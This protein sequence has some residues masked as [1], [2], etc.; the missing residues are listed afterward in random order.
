MVSSK[1]TP[2][3][4]KQDLLTAQPNYTAPKR[5]TR[6]TRPYPRSRQKQVL[7]FLYHHRIPKTISYSERRSTPARINPTRVLSGLEED[8]VEDGFRRPTAAEA[9]AY[10]QIASTESVYRWWKNRDSIWKG[11]M[12]KFMPPKW[13]H[14][15][16]ELLKRFKIARESNKIVTIHWFRRTA[17]QLWLQLYPHLPDLFVFSNGWFWRFL[18]RHDIVRRRITKVATKPP[19]ELVKVTNAFIQ[20]IRKRSRRE[21]VYQTIVLRSSPPY[22]P[23]LSDTWGKPA[24]NWK[25]D[26]LRRFPL[27][28]IVNLDETPLP[29]EF[30]SGYSYDFKGV[31]TVAGKSERSGWDKRQATIILY[32]MADGSTP[33]KPVII[34]HGKG[35]VASKENYD[36]RVDVHFNDTAYNNEELFHTW[37]SD[38]YQPYVAQ[39]AQGNE[40]SL[41]VMDAAS[42]HKTETILD[43]IRQAEPPMTT[44]L[45]PPG[46]TSLVQPLDTAV[47]GP[48]KK[49]LQEEA[50]VYMEELENEDRMPDSWAIKDRREMATVIVA[51]AWERLRSDYKL[52]KQS[53]IQC[54]ISIHPD[55]H[56]DHLINIKGV[57]NSSIDPNGWRGWSAHNSHAIVD[58]DFDYMTALISATEELKPSLKTVTLKQLQEECVHRGLAKSGTKADLLARLQMN[59]SQQNPGGDGVESDIGDEFASIDL[60]LGTPIP[61]TP[62]PDMYEIPN[63]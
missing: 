52:I 3:P 35:T 18:Q 5:V 45:I 53:F 62:M 33:F 32:I 21:D 9:A 27:N 60:E 28:L 29:F 50:D 47:N 12:P 6:D 55:G 42:F 39:H 30:L 22:D 63:N 51:R 4:A 1:R 40:E 23:Q 59:E 46:L 25:S 61:D 10:F 49:L 48:F 15:E 14:L 43:F 38:I 58:E 11:G 20:Y 57:A 44:A 8:P 26:S 56:E 13:P 54:G 7:L 36:N 19:E 2:K 17:Q 34:F 31:R 24:D 16:E 41:I 37:L